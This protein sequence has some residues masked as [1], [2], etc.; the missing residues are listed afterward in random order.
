MPGKH[1][2]QYLHA[3]RDEHFSGLSDPPTKPMH[4]AESSS[5]KSD[6][7]VNKGLRMII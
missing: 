1:P 4:V 3:V 7:Q 6:V 5:L 2:V